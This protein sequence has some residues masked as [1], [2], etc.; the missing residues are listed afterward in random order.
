MNLPLP[1]KRRPDAAVAAT[2]APSPTP[3][4][5]TSAAAAGRGRR[6]GLPNPEAA[7]TRRRQERRR[8]RIAFILGGALILAILAVVMVGVYQQFILPPRV[9]AGEVRDVRFT[10]GDLVERIRVLQ[11]INR[12]QGGRVDF[13]RVPFQLLTD[14]LHAEILRQ[15]AP[16]LGINVTAD[17]I[18][19][20][21]SD[22]FRPEPAPGQETDDAQLDAELDNAYIGFL[23]QVNLTDGDYRRIVEE[24]LQQ[25]ELFTRMLASLPEEAPQVEV[26]A[27]AM[28]INSDAAPEAVRERL[29]LGED[30]GAVSREI[31][32]SD[33][34]I[35][36]APEGA[37]PEF[38]PYLFGAVDDDSG[39]RSP[40]LLSPGQVSPPIYSD[41]TIFLIQVIGEL[42]TRELAPPMQFQMASAQVEQ[43]QDDQL[44]Q[45]SEEGWVKIN[46][47]SDRYAWVTDQVRLTAPR[48]TPPPQ[49]NANPL[50]LPQ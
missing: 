2:P 38:D 20:T 1:W 41:E 49:Q 15:A 16:G 23:T 50:Q 43:W 25:R 3:R 17:D 4:R 35:G 22:Q 36:W 39:E 47:D 13:S 5:M 42:E 32:G 33:G 19:Q 21:I 44:A 12:Y 46:F 6:P 24:R 28:G 34:Y 27:I 7:R 11:G 8:Q 26:Q 14:L 18:D 40:P 9:T 37:F 45:G 31:T 10:M 48:V 29:Q 30:F